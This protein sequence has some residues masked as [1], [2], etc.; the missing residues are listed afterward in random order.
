[1]QD[2]VTKTVIYQGRSNDGELFCIPM[3]MLTKSSGPSG[4]SFSGIAW[5]KGEIYNM[6]S[7]VWSS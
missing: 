7:K 5:F 1:M 3:K 4:Q 6:A 2:K